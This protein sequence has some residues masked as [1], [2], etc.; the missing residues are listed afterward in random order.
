[1]E[2]LFVNTV[3]GYYAGLMLPRQVR[4]A[5]R[6]ARN[7]G[8]IIATVTV[9]KLYEPLSGSKSLEDAERR[10][11][12]IFYD[13]LDEFYSISFGEY[14]RVVSI[15]TEMH[16]VKNAIAALSA[17][18][19]NVPP[20]KRNLILPVGFLSRD[21]ILAASVEEFLKRIPEEYR[22]SNTFEIFRSYRKRALEASV[23]LEVKS[24]IEKEFEIRAILLALRGRI[25]KELSDEISKILRVSEKMPL[26]KI[27]QILLAETREDVLNSLSDHRLYEYIKGIENPYEAYFVIHE[28]IPRLV[29]FSQI[30]VKP[31]PRRVY[32]VLKSLEWE[33]EKLVSVMNMVV[34]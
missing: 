8:E 10:L 7:L 29:G 24:M 34:L 4:S 15:I 23:G 31:S 27:R 33:V 13:I 5:L 18:K 26:E 14:K 22:Y 2:E 20:E 17:I 12:R 19:R 28:N 6:A 21:A 3:A 16:A 1:M 25:N 9:S 32:S 11:Y 30:P